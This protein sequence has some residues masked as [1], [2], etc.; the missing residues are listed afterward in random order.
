MKAIKYCLCLILSVFAI[1][2]FGQTN[3]NNMDTIVINPKNK[4]LDL[5]SSNNL[6]Q[7]PQLRNLG[8]QNATYDY[9]GKT[10][11]NREISRRRIYSINELVK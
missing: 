4:A 6:I 8:N 1:N 10:I 3:D 2:A 5:L 11:Y 9:I 7:N